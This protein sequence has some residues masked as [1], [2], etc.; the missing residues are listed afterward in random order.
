MIR[1]F[2]LLIIMLYW[3]NKQG[4]DMFD[5]AKILSDFVA[6]LKI[7]DIPETTIQNV[8][9][10]ILDYYAASIAGYRV[11]RK[12]NQSI[13]K[14]LFENGGKKESSVQFTDRK[15]PCT[16]AS[17]L[18][19]CFAH[20]ADMDDG[21]RKGMG[22]IGAH[23][24]SAVFALA[25][26]LKSTQDDMLVSIIAGY[27]VWCRIAAAAQPGLVHRGFHSTGTVGTIACAVACAKLLNLDSKGIYNAMAISVTQSS[28]LMFVVESGQSVKPINPANAA[29]CGMMSALLAENG[30]SGGEKPFEG[31]KGWFHA[32]TDSVDYEMITEGLNQKFCIDECYLKP[33]PSC[34]HT[35]CGLEAVHN[36]RKEADFNVHGIEKIYVYIYNNAI[37][38]AGQIKFPQNSDE[39]K[40]SIHYALACMLVKGHF[41]L[42]DLDVTSIPCDIAD[43]I[44]KIDLIPDN[45]MEN[46]AQG[47][48]GCK[49]C[50]KYND[51]HEAEETVLIPKGDPEN[52]MTF[53]EIREKLGSCCGNLVS[54]KQQESL[55][56]WIKCF[57]GKKDIDYFCMK[58]DV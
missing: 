1:I 37:Q 43:L 28:G 21:N 5:T 18:N 52:K 41:T 58:P 55:I 45:N 30:V 20:G 2:Y 39:A 13:E 7:E 56:E 16:E 47:I 57:G 22:H 42:D 14:L 48:R 24:I 3:K 10:F 33:Y 25:E 40:F 8:R 35:H 4:V 49:V 6:T 44:K 54:L 17:F 51:G 27:E 11:N 38:I 23:V 19:A 31:E 32:M 29:R 34:R 50:I 12:F 53:D 15:I 36:L 9:L 26:K 46:R